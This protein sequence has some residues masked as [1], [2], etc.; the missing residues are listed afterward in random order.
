MLEWQAGGPFWAS[1]AWIA[2]S[3]WCLFVSAHPVFRL[4]PAEPKQLATE[5][6]EIGFSS[7]GPRSI[8]KMNCC[9]HRT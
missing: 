1:S 8:F 2:D 4:H 9:S 3:E 7:L 6:A 5:W